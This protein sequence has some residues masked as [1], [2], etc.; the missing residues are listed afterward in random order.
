MLS[1]NIF[2]GD[3]SLISCIYLC[4]ELTNFLGKFS[5]VIAY[6]SSSES[7]KGDRA[8]YNYLEALRKRDCQRSERATLRKSSYTRTRF[9]NFF[10]NFYLFVS[11]RLNTFF[12]KLATRKL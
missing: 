6:K 12:T 4:K 11:K 3:L 9:T 10:Y 1:I 2:P 7:E 8:P 5:V